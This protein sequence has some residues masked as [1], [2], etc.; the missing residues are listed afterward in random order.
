MSA[1]VAPVA[2]RS[3]K[4]AS[5][6]QP[7]NPSLSSGTQGVAAL[8]EKPAASGTALSKAPTTSTDKP[9]NTGDTTPPQGEPA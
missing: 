8:D 3:E 6:R 7:G 5:T 2:I 1:P 4:P 9:I